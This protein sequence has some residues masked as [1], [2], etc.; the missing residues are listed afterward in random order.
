M[1][2]P[3]PL[4]G[5]E[6]PG[7]EPPNT[8][9]RELQAS[10][11]MSY[12]VAAAQLTGPGQLFEIETRDVLGTCLRVWKNAPTS[13][14][15][16]LELSCG[17]G[18]ADYLVYE[19]QRTTYVE[20]F[21]I[22][23]TLAHRLR[24]DLGIQKGDRVAIA[25]RNV[26]EWIMAFWGT[27]GAGGI[28]VPLNAWWTGAELAYGLEDSGAA[29]AFVDP[30]RAIRIS[31]HVGRLAHLRTVVTAG[32]D[33]TAAAPSLGP[34]FPELLGGVDSSVTLPDVALHPD[35]DATIFYTSGTTGTPKGAVGTHRNT[36]TNL[37][38]LFF[39]QTLSDLRWGAGSAGRAGA[40]TDRAGAPRTCSLLTV[41]LFHATGCHAILIPNTA[42][43]AKLVLMRRFDPTR[44]LELIEQERVTAFGGVPTVVMR[45][46]D[47]PDLARRDVSSVRSISYGG[48][49]APTDLV[50]RIRQAFGTGQP[51]NGYGLTETSAAIA[52]NTGADYIRK[53][54]SVGR[55]L[56]VIDVAVVPDKFAGSVPAPLD[57]GISGEL[58]VKGPSIVRCYWNRPEDTA[59]AITT[60][61]LHTGDIARIDEEGFI[62]I[63]DR[64]K[65]MVIRGGENVYC[66]EVENA[67]HSHPAVADCAVIGVPDPVLGEEVGAVIVLRPGHKVTADELV[68]HVRH[69]VAS[70]SVPTRMWLRAN[71][72]PRNPAGKLLKRALRDEVLGA[73]TGRAEWAGDPTAWEA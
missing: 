1:T 32:A 69:R 24:D 26:P 72:L 15:A 10:E 23:A 28:V 42:A 9:A 71:P 48:A 25:M 39:A 7:A 59:S 35:D 73:G 63:V 56:P 18:D 20:H 64:A 33:L 13:L 16:V 38:N 30:E 17:Y 62:F 57:P 46:L 31:P 11:A 65:D 8:G 21:W 12:D 60:G 61:W 6:R 14:R 43:G 68:S 66:V 4:P 3:A 44:A 36:C 2:P 55:P 29:V 34:T 41:P 40:G 51:G 27:V 45:V 67:L 53:P 49:P 58:W 54:D 70:F 47:S 22:A 50:R 52:L 5:P 19:G 37:M